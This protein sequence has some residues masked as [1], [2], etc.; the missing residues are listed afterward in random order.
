MKTDF[1][2]I[3][4]EGFRIAWRHKLLWIFGVF[5]GGVPW[6]P[7]WGR[8]SG[9]VNFGKGEIGL[10][11]IV[12]GLA[13][14]WGVILPILIVIVLAGIAASVVSI[15]GLIE[16]VNRIVRGVGEWRF[17]DALS[18]GLEHFWRVLGVELVGLICALGYV[19]LV[20]VIG[21]G[22]FSLSTS[23]GVI[24]ILAVLPVTLVVYLAGGATFSLALRVV[25][26]R[27]A[28]VADAIAEG[29]TLF[30]QNWKE[31]TVM[32]LIY[33]GIALGLGI[34]SLAVVFVFSL[35]MFLAWAAGGV[36]AVIS[37]I[38]GLLVTA[39]VLIVVGGFTNTTMYNLITLFYFELV[40][41]RRQRMAPDQTPPPKPSA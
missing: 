20:L 25:V 8:D 9:Y 37:V 13:S 17:R 10:S 11:E 21:V 36:G 29:W 38:L 2:F 15:G 1:G 5:A 24:Y 31:S 6:I 22:A 27:H 19:L 14:L 32:F 39:P 16:A 12:G 35:P 7:N 4:R 18:A 41:P 34:T 23:L 26:T 28:G 3:V 30:R 40:E 33:I